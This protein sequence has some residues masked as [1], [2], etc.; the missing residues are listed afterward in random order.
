MGN[1]RVGTENMNRR[2]RWVNMDVFI[3][4]GSK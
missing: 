4:G 3:I 2:L 1:D